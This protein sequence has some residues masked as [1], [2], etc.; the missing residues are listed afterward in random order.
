MT[1]TVVVRPG[2]AR[3]E[4]RNLP[5]T[6]GG[7]GYNIIGDAIGATQRGQVKYDKGIFTV[8]RPHT[9]A[10]IKGLAA[11]YGIVQ[12]IQHGGTTKCV[13]VCWNASADSTW[14]CECSCAGDNHATG[15]PIG[16]VV[17]EDGPAG[18]LSVAPAPPRTYTVRGP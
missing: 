3:T 2:G 5:F 8:S 15:K 9:T 10:L 16:R 14:E 18:A 13:S 4:V 11:K 6:R 12:V 7:D 17:S 1:V